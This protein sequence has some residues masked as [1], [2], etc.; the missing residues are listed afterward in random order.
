ML[1]EEKPDESRPL[2]TEIVLKETHPWYSLNPS[3][4]FRKPY[5]GIA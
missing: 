1:R 2:T 3:R 5:R 4:V